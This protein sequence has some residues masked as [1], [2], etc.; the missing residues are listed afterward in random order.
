MKAI[1]RTVWILSIVSLFTD[2]ASEMLY[3]VMPIY[4][5][6]I[7]FS[8]FLIGILE[9]VAEATAGL[10]KGYFGKMSDL[11]GRRLPF[12]RIGY[13]MS[14]FSRPI[15]AFFV[16]PVF[17]FFARTMDRF[18]KGVRTGAR[19]AILSEEAI[20]ATKGRVFGFHR[21]M[22]TLGALI[23]PILA[24]AYLYCYPSDYKNLF[25]IAF[26]PGI[27]SFAA[28]L[29]LKEK[30]TTVVKSLEKFTFRSFLQY[31]NSSPASYRQAVR[32]FLLFALFNSADVFLLLKAKESGYTDLQVIG[33]YIFYNLFYAIMAFPMGIL[34]DRF[35]LRNTYI[36]GLML[37]AIVYCGMGLSN[38]LY[39]IAVLFF[40]YGLYSAATEGI[41]KAW[42]SNIC[43]PADKATALG[44]YAGF[45]SICAL[46][47]S[48]FTGFL[49]Y[50]FGAAPT[51]FVTAFVALIVLIYFLNL[52]RKPQTSS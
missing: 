17:I 41:S 23:G 36:F 22:D 8:I 12:V 40:L 10:S 3:P 16:Q 18:G 39:V 24:L 48:T 6:S 21:S 35:G 50:Q 38:N 2:I 45:Q 33:L 31:W 14:T 37:F 43:S 52:G 47:A 27:L 5:Q 26:L 15:L 46:F 32:G 19:D 7:G 42:I 13:A 9:G 28:T 11:S 51:F 49:W 4:L 29:M 34:G 30:K 44:T 25:L 1:S 20:A